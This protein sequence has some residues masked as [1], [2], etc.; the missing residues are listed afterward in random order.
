[1]EKENF[2]KDSKLAIKG[3]ANGILGSFVYELIIY[4]FVLIVVT[5]VVSSNNV[6]AS[7]E[8]LNLLVEGVYSKYPLDI[9]V[10]CLSSVVVFLVFVYLLGF[11]KIKEIFKKAFNKKT[12][13]WGLIIGISLVAIS[14]IYNSIIIGLFDLQGTGN[15]NQNNVV[16]MIG[17][18][19]ILGC[20]SVVVLAPI[21]EEL[22]FRYCMFGGLYS[23]NKKFAY[24]VSAFVFMLMHA[25]A[26]FL[27][28]E[29][30][31][32]EFLKE[33]LYLPPYLISGL[34]LCYA[35]DKSD[36]LGSSIIAHAF[37][38]LVSFLSIVLL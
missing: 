34:L 2:I 15:E 6:I 31:N 3:I 16:N 29:G 9:I 30:F 26:S 38:N 23:K 27:G 25:I 22:T 24:M 36:N 8:Q 28:A 37:N 11:N 1:M 19:A 20:L 4:F 12:L 21:V 18:S 14:I 7:D 17:T 35:Y 5:N 10:S 33:L 32:L 13:K